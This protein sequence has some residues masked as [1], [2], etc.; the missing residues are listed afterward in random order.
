[1]K[2]R[3]VLKL[4]EQDI[5]EVT[6]LLAAQLNR[7]ILEREH[8]LVLAN[9]LR[10]SV[11]RAQ[12]LAFGVMRVTAAGRRGQGLPS[13]IFWRSVA[14]AATPPVRTPRRSRL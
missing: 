7:Q 13:Q 2:I 4:N 14:G 1:M 9:G 10:V 8:R 12:H 6:G 3:G 5:P 11:L